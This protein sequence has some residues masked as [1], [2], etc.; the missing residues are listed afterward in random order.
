MIPVKRLTK[1]KSRQLAFQC[2]GGRLLLA[3]D[4]Q[5]PYQPLDVD[6]D[7]AVSVAD[8][9]L[10]IDA[11]NRNPNAELSREQIGAGT[12]PDVTGDNQLTALD[13][14]R[15][16]NQIARDTPIVTSRL[17]HDSAFDNTT[18]FDLWTND[19]GLEFGISNADSIWVEIDGQRL[20]GLG[21]Q[22][23]D[24]GV[25]LT[26][27]EID[28][29]LGET[30]NDGV[31]QV[32]VG[33]S[34]TT[35]DLQF[36]F[37]LDRVSPAPVSEDKQPRFNLTGTE[38]T[39]RFDEVLASEVGDLSP[40]T[41]S[42][43][44][45]ASGASAAEV[46]QLTL[47][48]GDTLALTLDRSLVGGTYEI[49][50][51]SSIC[52]Q[53]GN[54]V[55]SSRVE[56]SLVK[57]FTFNV[58]PSTQRVTVQAEEPTV[59]ALWDATVQNAVIATSPGP[60][61]ASRA[62]AMM[63][64]AMYDA[65]SAYEGVAVSTVL[66]DDLQQPLV[67]NTPPN[68]SIA[69]SYAAYRVLVD[70]F[71]TEVSMFDETMTELG[72]RLTNNTLNAS[73]PAGI[74]N[75]MAAALLQQ[76]SQD[77]SNQK[78]T[79]PN[80][81]AGVPYSNTEIYQPLN[82]VG[83]VV[84]LDRWTPENVPIGAPIGSENHDHVQGFL[85][86]HWGTV[87]PFALEDVEAYRPETPEPF[88]LVNGIVNF[89]DKTI[90]L[91]N[92]S[93]VSIEKS[94]I[95]TVIN[96][97]YIAQ[98]ERV[99]EASADLTD[100]QKL[101]AEFW[102]DAKDTSFPPGTWMTFGQYVSAINEHTVDDDA[103]LFFA[104]SNAIFD[105]SIATWDAKIHFDYV[106]PVRSIRSLGELGLIG[107]FDA[108]RGGNVIQAW[109]PGGQTETILATD[110]LTYQT[111][112]GD[113]SP[114]FAE[115]TSGHSSFSAAGATILELFT[116]SDDFGAS[117]TFEPGSSRFEPGTVPAEPTTLNWPTF[118]SAADQAGLSRIYGGIHFDDGDL[119]GRSVGDD[120]A[121]RVWDVAQSYILGARQ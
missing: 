15:V 43:N 90:Q 39:I 105:A 99:V 63:H 88:L 17:R 34:Q 58:D 23:T 56:A 50:L 97:D 19:P 84:D 117:L 75:R 41:I 101:I 67:E 69:M 35:P 26:A 104:L 71:P 53:V 33:T 85:T 18:N 95:G 2:L 14:L 100:E 114:P 7:L 65:W 74:G 6:V 81:V 10:V 9:Q 66:A 109:T 73:T 87:E 24:S 60:T 61:V 28:A 121:A 37:N 108:D 91:D 48:N 32:A 44:A 86:P 4:F 46:R 76:R 30:L 31:H 12:F 111:P 8:A 62:Y 45:A 107:E 102:E 94:L 11:L 38:L 64:T 70:L 106:R 1:L 103:K 36:E 80:G 13:A 89:Q 82:P 98:A 20:E 118:R 21:S 92:G 29:L 115:Y 79:S 27:D 59:S 116:G 113:P 3:A 119:R 54:A 22:T 120:V 42:I 93:I 49:E 40:S 72:L 57:R 78:G 51:P 16:I 112:G 47:A 110:F 5:S 96:P 25:T 77:G 83:G 52:D 55:S 68:K